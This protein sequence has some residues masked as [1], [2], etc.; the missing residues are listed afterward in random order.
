MGFCTENL[1]YSTHTADEI[2]RHSSLDNYSCE[3]YERAILRH[4]RQKHNSK[5][6]EKTFVNRERLRDF[7]EWYK[8]QNGPISSYSDGY[9]K[10]SFDFENINDDTPLFFN[11]SS[12]ACAT[13]LLNEARKNPN[14]RVQQAT[15]NGVALG[16][17]KENN[18]LEP[19]VKRDIT[20]YMVSE[21]QCTV[22]EVPDILHTVLS[23]VVINQFGEI[24]KVT[25][26]DVFKVS[27]GEQ[28]EEWILEIHCIIIVGPI[29]CS[30]YTF[31]DGRYFIPAFHN[32]QVVYHQWTGTPKFMPHLYERDSVQPICNLQRKVIMYP[33][34]ENTENP[35]YFLCIDFNKPELLKPVQVPVYPELGDTVKI[36]GA[37]NQEWYGKVLNVNLTQ[38]KATVQ[39]YQE[40]N[41]PGIWSALK[42]EDEVNFRSIISLA[43]AK[44]TFGGFTI[45]GT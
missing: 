12:F 3:L 25:K 13:E 33:E 40:T 4:K 10:F 19:R 44:R 42:D 27:N 9:Q 17:V 43:T 11:E 38:R 35:S 31:V 26:N 36:K 32:R 41:R 16:K 2:K 1:E 45:N 23:A 15:Q 6:L 37:G 22:Q 18:G 29:R 21:L 24:I 34:P 20:R 14:V 7:L 30:F 5:G 8:R 28:T 39:W